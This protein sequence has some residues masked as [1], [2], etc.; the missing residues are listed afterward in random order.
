MSK[1]FGACILLLLALASTSSGA[2]T[3]DRMI[4]RA[5]HHLAGTV[6]ACTEK[7]SDWGYRHRTCVDPN[8]KEWIGLH[9]SGAIDE[10]DLKSGKTCCSNIYKGECR[11]TEVNMRERKVLVDGQWKDIAPNTKIVTDMEK[12][13]DGVQAMVCGEKWSPPYCIGMTSGQ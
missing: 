11:A 1:V 4:D 6:P 10:L 2:Q 9:E 12:L 13:P 8:G 7:P 5:K 3:L